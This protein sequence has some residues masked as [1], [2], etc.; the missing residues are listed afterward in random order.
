MWVS[1]QKSRLSWSWGSWSWDNLSNTVP[2]CRVQGPLMLSLG[3][4]SISSSSKT[5]RIFDFPLPAK[6]Q[7]RVRLEYFCSNAKTMMSTSNVAE[8]PLGTPSGHISQT[9]YSH[10]IADG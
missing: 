9:T 8:I 6:L 1:D 4:T 7:L 3:F 10:S 2:N 5:F